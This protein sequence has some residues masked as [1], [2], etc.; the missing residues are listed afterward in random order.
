MKTLRIRN[1]S[2]RCCTWFC[3]IQGQ[4]IWSMSKLQRKKF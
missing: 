1:L 4:I 3:Q 2:E